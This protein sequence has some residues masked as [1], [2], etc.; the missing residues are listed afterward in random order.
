MGRAYDTVV[1]A[2][3]A[4]GSKYKRPN[5]QCPAH[6][7]T[8]PSLTVTDAKD[9]VLL[10]CKAGCST[11][12]VVAALGLQM[13]DLFDEEPVKAEII[14]TYPYV[15]ENNQL[16]FEVVRFYP[17]DFKQRRP[18]L[19][20]GY[21]WKL[22][23][24][25]RVLYRLP[26]VMLVAHQGRRVYVVEG[27]KD[28][29][30][31]ERAGAVATCNPGG[32]GKWRDEYTEFLRGADVVVVA[33]RDKTGRDHAADVM[34]SLA[35]AGITAE[36]REAAVGKDAADHLAAGRSLEELVVPEVPE[37]SRTNNSRAD[38]A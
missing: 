16:L 2:L 4:R 31:V 19:N 24:T 22:G 15:D 28:V 10:N 17:R 20:G 5:W 11:E 37:P 30:H 23:D 32:A 26:Q 3:E 36:L 34:R 8:S 13:S 9:R 7:D 18:D 21:I 38:R 12:D 33:D 27:E 35:S 29:H 1:A 25:R 6:A 14:G